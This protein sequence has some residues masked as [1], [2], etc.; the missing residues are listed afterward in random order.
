MSK[1][2]VHRLGT[3]VVKETAAMVRKK[4]KSMRESKMVLHFDGKIFKEYTK[5]RKLKKG[6]YC[7]Q[8]KC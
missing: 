6:T 8:Y 1:S 5:G 2:N 7:C 4:I 3:K